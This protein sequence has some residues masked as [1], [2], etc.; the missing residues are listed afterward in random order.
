MVIL[1]SFIYLFVGLSIFIV[2]LNLMAGGLEKLS[3]NKVQA[4]LS[5]ISNNRV[6]SFGFGALITT[7]MQSSSSENQ[8]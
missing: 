4:G 6:T 8:L 7:I 5:K 1:T 2:G 3:S